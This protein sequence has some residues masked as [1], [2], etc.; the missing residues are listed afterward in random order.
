VTQEPTERGSTSSQRIAAYGICLHEEAIL[1]VR[2]SAQTGVPGRWFLPG[3]GV[4]HGE[5]PEAALLRELAEE[6]G[7]RGSLVGLVGVLSD[8]RQLPEGLTLH[9]IRLIYQLSDLS[10]ELVH[11]RSGSSDLA[12]WIPLADAGSYPIAHYAQRAAALVGIDLQ[13]KK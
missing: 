9:S 10:G 13:A 5:H 7:L 12:A 11:E 1:L 3:G 8:L 2:A 6:T 4:D